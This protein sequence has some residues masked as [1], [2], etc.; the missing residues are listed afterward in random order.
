M[1]TSNKRR[2]KPF[3]WLADD[4]LKHIQRS[5]LALVGRYHNRLLQIQRQ[6]KV[7][8]PAKVMPQSR[9]Q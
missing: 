3:G 2:K 9:G 1:P 4:S 7:Y 5:Q 6:S 8:P